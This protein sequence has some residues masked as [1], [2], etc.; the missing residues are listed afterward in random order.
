M[1]K[2]SEGGITIEECAN[3]LKNIENNKTS[4]HGRFDIDRNFWD[5]IA[6]YAVESFNYVFDSGN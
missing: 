1:A 2:T 5:V 4:R 6:K 3:A